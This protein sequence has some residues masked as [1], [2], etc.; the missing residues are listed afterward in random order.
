VDVVVIASIAGDLLTPEIL[1]ALATTG[2]ADRSVNLVVVAG[3]TAPPKPSK[4]RVLRMRAT[5]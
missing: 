4:P 1:V 2:A 5:T 3:D